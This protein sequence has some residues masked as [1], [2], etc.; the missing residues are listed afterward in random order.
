MKYGEEIVGTFY[1]KELG[2]TNQKQFRV[3]KVVMR[4]EDYPYATQKG[5]DSSLNS[6]T[7]KKDIVI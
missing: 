5:Y 2:K 7:D 3:K 4:K 6:S 1:E